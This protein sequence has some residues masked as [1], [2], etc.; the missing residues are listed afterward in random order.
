MDHAK[1][2]GSSMGQLAKEFGYDGIDL[3]SGVNRLQQ[4]RA[5]LPVAAPESSRVRPPLAIGNLVTVAWRSVASCG[6]GPVATLIEEL[7]PRVTEYQL[8]ARRCPACRTRIWATLPAD[9]PLRCVG[10]RVQA[11]LALLTGACRLSRRQEQE[12]QRDVFGVNLSLGSIMALE[13]DTAGLLA[14]PY[15]E[16]TQAVRQEPVVFVD[17]SSWRG[18]KTGVQY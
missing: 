18:L 15:A 8:F 14:Q 9:A 11:V 3:S 10:P 13:A 4:R 17:E 2:A 12:L 1:P 5:G 16:I 6:A 7:R